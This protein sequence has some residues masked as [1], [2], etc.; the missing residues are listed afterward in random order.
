M[1]KTAYILMLCAAL[2][3]CSAVSVFAD[4]EENAPVDDHVMLI[5]GTIPEAVPESDPLCDVINEKRDVNGAIA[6]ERSDALME[7]AATRAETLT[8]NSKGADCSTLDAADACET[9]IR[10]N[11]DINTMISS[12][13]MSAKQQKTLIYSGYT[14]FGYACNEEQNVWVLLFTS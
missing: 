7:H 6:L 12:I 14:Q 5:T 1:K 4:T 10:G 13:M 8:G 9:V 2:L 3:G 11:A